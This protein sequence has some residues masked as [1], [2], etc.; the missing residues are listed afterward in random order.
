M[1]AKLVTC[2]AAVLLLFSS[3]SSCRRTPSAFQPGGTARL[4]GCVHGRATYP[5]GAEG[6]AAVMLAAQAAR[7]RMTSL[8]CDHSIQRM[9][10][11]AEH[12]I[13]TT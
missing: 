7:G 1:D 12:S 13:N 8:G 11:Q 6:E 2:A 9:H 4:W 10:F 3:I 5:P